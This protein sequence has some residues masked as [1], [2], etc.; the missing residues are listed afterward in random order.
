ME[1]TVTSGNVRL[2]ATLDLPTGYVRGG[3]IPLHGSGEGQRS[4]IANLKE[5]RPGTV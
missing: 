5:L 4:S 2:P 3:L 1:L